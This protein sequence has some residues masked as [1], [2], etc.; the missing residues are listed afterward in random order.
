MHRMNTHMT[1][2]LQRRQERIRTR[3][4][5]PKSRSLKVLHGQA[6]HMPMPVNYARTMTFAA[7]LLLLLVLSIS[8]FARSTAHIRAK[9]LTNGINIGSIGTNTKPECCGNP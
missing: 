5:L 9:K 7:T 8:G 4:D 3:Y 6:I 1:L 2:C